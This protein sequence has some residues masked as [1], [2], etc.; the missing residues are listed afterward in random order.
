[1]VCDDE[2]AGDA[3]LAS[4]YT[5]L[6]NLRGTGDAALRSHHSV[7]TNLHVMSDLAEIINFHS[8]ADDSG[9]HLGFVNRS[10]CANLYI[11]ANHHV[12]DMFDFFPRSR[13]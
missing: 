13:L 5:I 6:A 3:Y 1:M 2:V 12:S 7:I 9:L 11:I 10:A 4:K 8:I